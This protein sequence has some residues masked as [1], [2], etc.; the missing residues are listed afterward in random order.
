M[1][2]QYN[3][4]AGRAFPRIS[5]GDVSE[6]FIL[7]GHSI[8]YSHLLH[9]LT[10]YAAKTT[11]ELTYIVH[12]NINCILTESVLLNAPIGYTLRP[13]K[14]Q[15]LGINLDKPGYIHLYIQL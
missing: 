4:P 7:E 14:N 15:L 3:F 9:L 1:L 11:L 10:R 5:S 2:A 6:H 8:V 13:K 12:R